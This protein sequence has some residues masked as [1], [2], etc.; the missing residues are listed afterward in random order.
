MA[1]PA[2]VQASPSHNPRTFVRA[3]GV[4][5]L[6]PRTI[7]FDAGYDVA[8]VVSHLEQSGHLMSRLKLSPAAWLIANESSTRAKIAAA[9]Q[10]KV[11]VVT[12]AGPFEIAQDRGRLPEYLELCATLGI[13]RI[14]AGEGFTR[15]RH[16]PEE[17]VRLAAR[18]GLT[19]QVALG[20]KYGAPLDQDV[21][22]ER[23]IDRGRRWLEAGARQIVV[24]GR[25]SAQGVALY[26]E[27]ARPNLKFAEAFVET[28]G[29]E[30]TVFE[31][32]T[33]RGQFELLSHFG[34]RVYL[35]QVRLEQLLGVEIYRRGLHSDSYRRELA[36]RA[37]QREGVP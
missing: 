8:T 33:E 16:T 5:D 3:L 21:A 10:L 12:G 36:P 13:D 34:Q 24:E 31:A 25:A 9:Q 29:M 23:L 19:V 11:P 2:D 32:P 22:A 27:A 4:P 26:D 35:S 1:V 14:E 37:V 20:G 17:I 30:A 28:W 15:P 7:P 6:P 18:F